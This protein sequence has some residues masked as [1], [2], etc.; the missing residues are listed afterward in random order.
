VISVVLFD[1]DDTLFAHRLAVNAGARSV[2]R[3]LEA[4]PPAHLEDSEIARWG[5]LE[6]LHYTRYLT[7]ELDY[8]GQRRAR[9]R[10]FLEP[11]GLR[12]DSDADAERWF[13]YYSARYREAW[14]LYPDTMPML[15]R[16][17]DRRLGV[18]TN[19][20][21]GNQVAK[22]DATGLTPQFEHVVASAEVGVTKPDARIFRIACDR[23]GV[24]PAEAVYVG[25]RLHTDAVGAVKAGLGGIWIDRL[26]A[27][28][29][30]LAE[31]SAAGVPVVNSL[32]EILPLLN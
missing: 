32:T 13:G 11:H 20:E 16:L 25:D 14:D 28:S 2:L 15:E 4:P 18:I 8:L 31:A 7:G 22:M 5:A 29:D 9:V 3:N 10:D 12:F 19:G 1:L 26:G 30:E 23:F 21:L 24:E 6:E 27:T 17:A